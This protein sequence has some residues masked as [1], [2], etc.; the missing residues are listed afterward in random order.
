MCVCVYARRGDSGVS[1]LCHAILPLDLETVR[2][3]ER[4]GERERARER[5]REMFIDNQMRE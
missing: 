4:E 2:E 3:W 5:E 1:L